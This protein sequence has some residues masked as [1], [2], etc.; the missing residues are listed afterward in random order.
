MEGRGKRERPSI[1]RFE[2]KCMLL[3]VEQS[4]ESVCPAGPE[5]PVQLEALLD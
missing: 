3:R 4:T 1:M 2:N 5:H